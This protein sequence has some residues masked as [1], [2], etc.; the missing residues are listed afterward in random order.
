MFKKKLS[1]LS[2]LDKIILVV[3]F[4]GAIIFSYLFF[5]KSS[6]I[7]VT[8][9]IGEENTYFYPWKLYGGTRPWFGLMFKPG[10]QEKDGLGRISAEVINVKSY[11]TF[12]S[13]QAAYLTVRLKTIYNKATNQHTYKG[14]D[15]LVGQ[16]IKL[17]LD[18]IFIE[19]LITDVEGIKNNREE[20]ELIIEAQLREETPTYPESSGTKDYIADAINIGDIFKDNQG[21]TIIEVLE[22]DT[23]NAK[24]AVTTSDGRVVVT[25]NPLRKDVFLKLKA[26]TFLINNR[27]YIF[28]DVPVLI[29][30]LIPLNTNVL[31]IQPEVTN[32]Q[33]IN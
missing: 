13:R 2:N 33:V 6:F 12:P 15:I 16:I 22:K 3:I 21:N 31:S 26:K 24:K 11:D 28:D 27:Y 17:N 4:T 29:G 20:K 18:K 7:T 30:E 23:R 14:S 25:E 32:I 19:G 1:K 10:M 5:R 8:L 9:K